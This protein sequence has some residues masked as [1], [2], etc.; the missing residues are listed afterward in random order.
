M[1]R[2]TRLPLALCAL[3]VAGVAL[4]ACT[5]APSPQGWA[6]PQSVSV[7]GANLTIAAH[8]AKL[9]AL[10]PDVQ[11]ATWQFP[12]KDKSTYPVSESSAAAL[13][14][15]VDQASIGQAQKTTLDQKIGQ[16]NI[17][18]P[19]VND[20]KSAIDSSGAASDVR[21]ALK[22]QVDAVTKANSD[23]L[24]GLQ[25][26]YGEMALSSDNST[27][28]ATAFKGYVFAL[29]PSNGHMRWF[30]KVGA[31]M[32]GGV[33]LS[34][35]GKTAYYGTKGHDIIAADAATG[36]VTWDVGAAGEVWSTPVVDSGTIYV[37]SLDGTVYAL[38]PDGKT[39]WTFKSANAGIAG[40]PAVA[41]GT[42]FVGAF[43]NRL[44]AMNAADG[45]ELWSY[46]GGNWFWG[47][48]VVQD[49]TVYAANLDGKVYAVDAGNGSAK[50]KTPFDTGSPV[51]SAPT[52]VSG[53]LFVANRSVE[54]YK[55]DLSS[56]QS[57][58]AP[59][60]TGSTLYANLTPAPGD[61]KLFVLPQSAQLLVLNAADL[62]VS[63]QYSLAQ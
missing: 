26:F 61:G 7:S 12:P 38:D 54:V 14:A 10:P 1:L 5:R 44:Y 9:Y 3:A 37:T 22:T 55:L 23:A 52:I 62:T 51:R 13:K 25:A 2:M 28:Y 29:D 53:A 46:S 40:T 4:A 17:S 56:G 20:L 36:A 18:G 24:S 33:A 8:R 57:A 21:S 11:T 63:S 59:Y 6:P 58:G 34:A 41:G 19:S 31:E 42:L 16:L 35:D 15:A 32:V 39:K 30:H 27:L 49:G 43:D 48:P 50:W 47:T 60:K 45:K